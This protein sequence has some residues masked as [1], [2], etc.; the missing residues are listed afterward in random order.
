MLFVEKEGYNHKILP[1]KK[2]VLKLSYSSKIMYY[3]LHDDY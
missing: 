3:N 2:D 1:F